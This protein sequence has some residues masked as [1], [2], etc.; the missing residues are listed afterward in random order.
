MQAI[1]LS[2]ASENLQTIKQALV[3]FMQTEISWQ[4]EIEDAL[5]RCGVNIALSTDCKCELSPPST[6]IFILHCSCKIC[7]ILI[8]EYKPLLKSG[9]FIRLQLSNYDHLIFYGVWCGQ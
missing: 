3:D 1:S 7:F 8:P 9:K 6:F 4:Q 5:Q 2:G